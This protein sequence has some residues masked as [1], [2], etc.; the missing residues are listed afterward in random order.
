MCWSDSDLRP[1]HLPRTSN[2]DEELNQCREGTKC[3]QRYERLRM[4]TNTSSS[5]LRQIRMERR[6]L[7]IDNNVTIL[8]IEGN[9]QETSIVRN[10]ILY[11]RGSG[12]RR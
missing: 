5:I 11:L 9:D 7:E 8:G 10:V 2:N 3:L 6:C 12:S 1:S 4:V